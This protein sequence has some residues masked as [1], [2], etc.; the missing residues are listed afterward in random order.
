VASARASVVLLSSVASISGSPGLVA[1]AGTKGAL[2]AIV[3]SAAKELGPKSIR[4]NAIAPGYVQTPMY[5]EMKATTP[6][7]V[8]RKL[9]EQHF[10][11]IPKPE[12]V[13]VMAAYLLSDAA[14]VVTGTMLV[15]DGGYSA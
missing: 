15:I 12:E 10:L 3:R 6:G 14:R 2:N 5:D 4:V 13:A 11:G 8:I 7:E 1:Y 9:E